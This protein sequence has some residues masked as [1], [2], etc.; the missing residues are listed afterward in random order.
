MGRVQART[1]AST[2]REEAPAADWRRR[3]SR[4]VLATAA[5]LGLLA[6]AAISASATQAAAT[7][8]RAVSTVSHAIADP[9]PCVLPICRPGCNQD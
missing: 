4:I 1:V 5:G 2:N 9:C 7:S 3:L 8:P 6:G